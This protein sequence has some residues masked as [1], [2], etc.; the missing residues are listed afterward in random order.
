VNAQAKEEQKLQEGG[1]I[2]L[3]RL[4]VDVGDTEVEVSVGVSD[5]AGH[6]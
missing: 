4:P 5:M 3:S 6:D 1:K 2:L